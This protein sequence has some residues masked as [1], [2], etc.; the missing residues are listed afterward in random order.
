MTLLGDV[1]GCGVNFTNMSA[2]FTKNGV[3]LGTAFRDLKGTLYA[4][5][6]LRTPGEVVEANFGASKFKF[7]IDHYYK[8]WGKTADV[9]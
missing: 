9:W 2:F 1:I 8:V 3:A 5:V 6:G 7:D 4:A